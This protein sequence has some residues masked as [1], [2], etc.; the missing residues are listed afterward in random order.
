MGGSRAARGVAG[1]VPMD[2]GCGSRPTRATTT[3][4]SSAIRPTCEIKQL[5]RELDIP[6]G[7]VDLRIFQ[8]RNLVASETAEDIKAVLGIAKAQQ[9]RG[10]AAAPARRGA[11]GGFNPQAQLI[12]MLQQQAFSVPGVE[13]G[14]KVE[15]VEVVPND[16][17]NSLLVS[18]PPE[19]MKVIEKVIGDLENLEGREIVGIYEYQLEHA[20]MEDILPLLQDIFA[21]AGAGGGGPS[22]PRAGGGMAAAVRGR[23]GGSPGAL[24]P[25]TV[26]GD[27]R[28]NKIIFTC[29]KK[30]EELVRA[31]IQKLDIEGALA[32]AELYVCKY[33]D[34]LAIADTV[35]AISGS[36]AGGGG[37]RPGRGGGAQS[38]GSDIRI[39]AD[40]ATN[41]IVVFAT[42]DK[43]DAIFAQI[44]ALMKVPCASSAKS[45]WFTPTRSSWPIRCSKC[46][47][48]RAARRARQAGRQAR[49]RQSGGS[50]ERH[51]D[52]GRQGV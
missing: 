35:Q 26:S 14:A 50:A 51:H 13:G 22:Q 4:L 43:R 29:E 2:N 32:D 5:L 37:Q 19:V 25:V 21:A 44:Q 42:P 12:E 39:A 16:V 7:E 30:D 11:A 49:P 33:G 9:K 17:T 40:A 10:G 28:V 6:P 1:P 23:S 8:L 27:P 24:G 46:S 36:G 34:A 52:H 41:T 20:K 48:A 15:L 45:P 18:A 38:T 47:A 31:Q 3:S